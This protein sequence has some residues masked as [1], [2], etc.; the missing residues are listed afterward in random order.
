MKRGML[1][2]GLSLGVGLQLGQGRIRF[3]IQ[4][5]FQLVFTDA[6]TTKYRLEV[7]FGR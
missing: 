6:E 1:V 2:V 7:V 3:E 5:A 4:P